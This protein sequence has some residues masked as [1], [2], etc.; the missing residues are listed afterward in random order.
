MAD[1]L[2]VITTVDN[3]NA[4]RK[5]SRSAVEANLAASGQVT[6]P[7]ETTYRHLGEVS[8]G[9]EF[10][11][12]FRTACDRREALE[13]HLLDNHPYDSGRREPRQVERLVAGPGVVVPAQGVLQGRDRPQGPVQ[14]RP[15]PARHDRD[16]VAVHPVRP[17][18]ARFIAGLVDRLLGEARGTEVPERS[19]Q[20]KSPGSLTWG[21]GMERMT[22]IEPAL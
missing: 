16:L 21:F 18:G 4:A 19:R 12:T 13:K 10:Q 1:F 20:H 22:G 6:G 14:L 8:E 7:I 5:L 15:A 2:I 3:Q 11:V 17:A 9:T